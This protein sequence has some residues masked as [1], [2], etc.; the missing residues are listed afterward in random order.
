MKKINS[1][2]YGHIIVILIG[3][4]LVAV[5][6]CMLVLL[7]ITRFAAFRVI[8]NLSLAVGGLISVFLAVLLAVELTQDRRIAR[9]HANHQN[10][11]LP[12]SGGR[13]ECQHCGS[14][15]VKRGEKTCPVCGIQFE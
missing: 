8:M 11:A 1:I 4:F 15:T 2:G 10:R 5:P 13:Y 14:T 6:L 7:Q 3:I 9:Y 12:L